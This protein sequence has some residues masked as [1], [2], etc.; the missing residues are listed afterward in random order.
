MARDTDRADSQRA[1]IL[2]LKVARSKARRGGCGGASNALQTAFDALNIG[3][4]SIT[5]RRFSGAIKS[6]RAAVA[7]CRKG[8]R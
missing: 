6:V 4:T 1:A 3:G 7:A 8:R 2:L 5:S